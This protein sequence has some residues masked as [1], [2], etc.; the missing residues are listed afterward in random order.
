MSIPRIIV[1]HSC[2]DCPFSEFFSAFH[3]A[4]GTV[5]RGLVCNEYGRQAMTDDIPDY[6]TLEEHTW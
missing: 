5:I 2:P 4:D 3:T 6:C 1:I